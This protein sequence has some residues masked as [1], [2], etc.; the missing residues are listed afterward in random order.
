MAPYAEAYN[1]QPLSHSRLRS[2]A[3]HPNYKGKGVGG[4][5][6]SYRIG[7]AHLCTSSNFHCMFFMS[8]G[9]GRVQGRGREGLGADFV[10]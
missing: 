9:K 7:W 10:S 2:P 5:G 1:N 4:E 6:L 3:F 8:V